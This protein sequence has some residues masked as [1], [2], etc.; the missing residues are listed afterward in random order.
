MSFL[1]TPLSRGSETSQWNQALITPPASAYTQKKDEK[2]VRRFNKIG[3][4]SSNYAV[5]QL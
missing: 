3:E 2:I 1:P 5:I 4:P